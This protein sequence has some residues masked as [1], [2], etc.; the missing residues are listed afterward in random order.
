MRSHTMTVPQ[1]IGEGQI[2]WIEREIPVPA[3]DQLLIRVQANALCGSDRK[4]FYQGSAYTPG[5]EVAGV[6]V[7][8]GSKTT[9]APG[10]SGVVFARDFCGLCR[11]CQLGQTSQCQRKRA[12]IGF[13]APGGYDPYIVVYESMFFPIDKSISPAEGTLLLDIMGTGS[14]A[15][16]RAQMMHPDI[17]SMLVLGAGPIGLGTLA[18]A[19]IM[20]GDEVPVLISDYVPYRLELASKLKGLT[21]SLKE[22]QLEEGLA[23]HG[24]KQVDVVIDASGKESARQSGLQVLERSGVLVLVGHG[25]G[26][27]VEAAPDLINVEKSVLGS[28]YFNF[29]EV[30]ENYALMKEHLPYLSQIITHRFPIA[31]LEEAYRLFFEQGLTGKVIVEHSEGEADVNSI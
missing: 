29:S 2:K 26:L 3:D 6:V 18:M 24:L 20:L 22:Q 1:F 9:T 13:T 23:A 15:I 25:E 17:R 4:Q 5:H 7:K 14:H 8:G 19:K 27:R 30:A 11:Q 12:V 21:I 28:D 10:T 16:K 31:R